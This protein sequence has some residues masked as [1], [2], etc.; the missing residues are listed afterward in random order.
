MMSY[1]TDMDG[2]A[3][4]TPPDP[5]KASCGIVRCFKPGSVFRFYVLARL[6]LDNI[7]P[8]VRLGRFM[9]KAE[10][11][12]QYPVEIAVVEGDYTVS[13]LLN[14]ND[15]ASEP[16]LCDVIVYAL[17]GRLI[18]NAKFVGARYLKAKFTDGE[19]V[20]LPLEMGYYRKSLCSTWLENAA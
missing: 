4:S 9:A 20:K 12:T 6:Y 2:Y 16:S 1:R 5:Q 11:V 7:P 15:M 3:L 19:A 18:R 14:W 17:P 13:S 10:I 8:L